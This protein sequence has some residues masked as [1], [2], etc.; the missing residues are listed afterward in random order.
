MN[1]WDAE[2]REQAEIALSGKA[3]SI[4]EVHCQQCLR[5]A[6]AEIDR[7]NAENR[8]LDTLKIVNIG[9]SNSITGW[10][11]EADKQRTEADHLREILREFPYFDE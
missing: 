5:R 3:N 6:V 9:L 1:G 10:Q 4:L 8:A 2:E 7:L 11:E